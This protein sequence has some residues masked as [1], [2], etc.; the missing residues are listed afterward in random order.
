[1]IEALKE[2]FPMAI[3]LALSPFP[4]IAIIMILMTP[5]AKGNALGFLLGWFLGIYAIG[6]LVYL[7]PGL[8]SDQGEPTAISGVL[9]ILVGLVLLIFAIRLWL[10]KAKTNDQVATPKIFKK[11]DTL[12]FGKSIAI[13]PLFSVVNVKNMAFSAAGAAR[14]NTSLSDHAEFFIS[15]A[16]FALTA[17]L[18]LIFP[19]VVFIL[20]GKKIE[21]RFLIW[22]QW[23]IKNNKVLLMLILTFI[24]VILIK[25]GI[26]IL[27]N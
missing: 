11:M 17:S 10:Q 9:R 25:A 8:K 5:R 24:S 2:A 27:M 7:I 21:H 12:D 20:I 23:L 19:L 14:L 1:M 16:F 22:K 13:G 26:G 4:V 6:C 18:T 15:L 3:G